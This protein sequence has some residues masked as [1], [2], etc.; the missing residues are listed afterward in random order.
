LTGNIGYHHIHHL[1][2]R[3]PNYRLRAAFQA[4]PQL[5]SVPTLTLRTSL[6]C[7]RMKLWDEDLDRMVRF[8][9]GPRVCHSRKGAL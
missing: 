2:P 3:V 7:A 9:E 5:Q 6:Q 8:P 1:A 4:I